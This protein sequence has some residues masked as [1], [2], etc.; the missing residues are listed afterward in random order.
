MLLF[1][2][3]NQSFILNAQT[4]DLN[5]SSQKSE[6]FIDNIVINTF[7][8]YFNNMMSW[9]S[10]RSLNEINKQDTANAYPYISPDGLRIYFTQGVGGITNNIYFASRNDI[11]SH[12]NNTQLLSSRIPEGSFS[13]WL[14]NDELEI[15][16]VNNFNLYFTSR[17][18]ISSPFIDPIQI[19]LVKNIQGWI[20]GPSLTPDKQEL[21]IYNQ[22]V[23]YKCILKFIQSDNYT[24]TLVDTLDVPSNSIINPGQLSKNGLKYYFSLKDNFDSTKLFLMERYDITAQFENLSILN[25][26]INS[27]MYNAHPSV[28]SE[29]NI[30][31]FVRNNENSWVNNNLFIASNVNTGI[32]L[33][34]E[35]T[36]DIINIYPNPCNDKINVNFKLS[37]NSLISF[38]VYDIYGRMVLINEDDFSIGTHNK[39]LTL[40]KIKSRG[41]YLLNIKVGNDLKTL[42]FIKTD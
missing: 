20:S 24:Y 6:H 8:Y 1:H 41:L 11:N 29:E 17:T 23:N 9:D 37:E 38:S 32:Q 26:N 22:D 18:S 30:L 28:S 42:R 36:I 40:N 15:Y 12:F 4:F 5:G 16:Y 25:S 7:D 2:L 33:H 31:V 19:N 13:C 3:V 27:T 39:I 21:Y 35:N 34:K 10:I 14:T